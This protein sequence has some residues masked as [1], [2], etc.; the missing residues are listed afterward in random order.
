MPEYDDDLDPDLD[1]GPDLGDPGA[2]TLLPPPLMPPLLPPRL[3]VRLP[4]ALTRPL[5]LPL[6]LPLSLLDTLP[7]APTVPLP[8]DS[9]LAAFLPPRAPLFLPFL[10]PLLPL[11]ALAPVLARLRRREPPLRM[12]VVFLGLFLRTVPPPVVPAT[13]SASAGPHSSEQVLL[14][15]SLRLG[16]RG[17][18]HGARARAGGCGHT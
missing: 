9:P 16:R 17:R 1:P 14:E 7:A 5:P 10:L 8:L 15:E 18:E 3:R 11:R 13:S 4:A 12:G 6:T 2:T